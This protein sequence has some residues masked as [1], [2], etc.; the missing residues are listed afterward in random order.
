MCW[1]VADEGVKVKVIANKWARHPFC[2][3]HRTAANVQTGVKRTLY[4]ALCGLIAFINRIVCFV[5]PATSSKSSTPLKTTPSPNTRNVGSKIGS[6]ANIKHVPGGGNVSIT[7]TVR[8]VLNWL[9]KM[10][11]VKETSGCRTG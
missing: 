9:F 2:T 3:V 11:M 6:T 7:S 5:F 1:T 4:E 10:F 8:R